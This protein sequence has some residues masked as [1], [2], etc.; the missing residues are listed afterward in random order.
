MWI[1]MDSWATGLLLHEAE[2]EVG[3]LWTIKK[4]EGAQGGSTNAT[5]AFSDNEYDLAPTLTSR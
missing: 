1:D 2:I 3:V 4:A 5:Q